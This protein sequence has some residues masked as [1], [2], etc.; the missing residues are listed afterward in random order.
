MAVLVDTSVWSLALRRRPGVLSEAERF[1][2]S[3]LQRLIEKRQAR[4]IGPIR[5]KLLSGIRE[6]AQYERLRDYLRAFPDEHIT[7]TDY[8]A[9]ADLDNQCRRAGLSGSA[10]DLLICA[11]ALD[12]S[13]AIL[14]TDPDFG[15][16]ARVLPIVLS[17]P[18]Q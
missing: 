17:P 2:A 9:A 15:R 16:F 6:Q 14:T 1:L 18:R 8:E 10:V 7:T 4:L 12:R 3:E 5:Q 13:W 11:V